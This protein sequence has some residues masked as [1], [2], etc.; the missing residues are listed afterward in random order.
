[1]VIGG[2]VAAS[3]TAGASPP[4]PAP[5]DADLIALEDRHGAHI[6]LWAVDLI[7]GRTLGHRADERLAMC[8]TFKTYAVGR[9]LQLAAGGALDLDTAVP[10]DAADI[11]VDSPVTSTRIGS[12][13]SLAELCDA[14]LTRS[15][16]TAG[17]ALLRRIGGPE[18]VTT[19][20]RAVG[21]E[22]TRLDRW[23][24]DLNEAL[25][26]DPRDTTTPRA[27][28]SGYRRLLVDDALDS[29]SRERLVSWMRGNVTSGKRFRAGLPAGWTSADK[30]GAGGFG[31]TNDAGLLI[32]P[33]GQRVLL[34]V[35]TRSS[36]ERRDSDPL[37]A[38]IA[39]TVALTLSRFGHH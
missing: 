2:A 39:D 33:S 6:G 16:N 18:A 5:A 35:L 7:S 26:G 9:V 37:N 23:E 24:P 11:V 22:E 25:P 32:G 29:R 8:S 28:N 27:L 14:A 1:M 30:T 10:I 4:Q 12:S 31:T 3:R 15:D 17:N 19:F 13:M 38:A 36:A 34:A 20:A 21:D